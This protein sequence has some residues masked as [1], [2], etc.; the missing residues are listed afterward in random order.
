MH[1]G[2]TKGKRTH[3]GEYEIGRTLGAFPRYTPNIAGEGS[4]GKVKLDTNTFTGE[5]VSQVLYCSNG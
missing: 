3:I 1:G 5:K 4:F 2:R